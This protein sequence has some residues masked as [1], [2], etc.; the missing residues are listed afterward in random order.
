MMKIIMRIAISITINFAITAPLAI[1]IV[2]KMSIFIESNIVVV[3]FICVIIAA[4]TIT[5]PVMTGAPRFAARRDRLDCVLI[6]APKS[7]AVDQ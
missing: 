1:I 6:A 2:S 5:L 3:I 4:I 7:R